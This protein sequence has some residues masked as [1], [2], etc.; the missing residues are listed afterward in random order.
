MIKLSEINIRFGTKTVFDHAEYRAYRGK[1]NII[2]GESGI[3]KTTLLKTILFEHPCMYF[4]DDEELGGLNEKEQAKFLFQHVSAVEQE[5]LFIEDLTLEE[6]RDFLLKVSGKKKK[7]E[8]IAE[9]FGLNDFMD[10][11]PNQLSV[12]ERTRAALWL[13][14]MKHPDILIL[15]EPTASLDEENK[16]KVI[17]LLKEYSRE[18]IVIASSHEKRLIEEADVLYEI[19]DQKLITTI[20]ETEEAEGK[21]QKEIINHAG[22]YRDV[23]EQMDR[24]HKW[25]SLARTIVPALTAA[26][27][28]ISLTFN[29]ITMNR[30]QDALN[31]MSSTEMIVYKQLMDDYPYDYTG[32]TFPVSE[33]EYDSLAK[34][35]GIRKVCPR[36]DFRNDEN[37]FGLCDTD[38][39]NYHHIHTET[40]DPYVLT[41]GEGETQE[42]PSIY[43]E[44]EIV[45]E[46]DGSYSRIDAH[47]FHVYYEG[48][49]YSEDIAKT[50]NDS[51]VYIGSG[52]YQKICGEKEYVQP[53]I[54][55]TVPV[56]AYTCPE[57]LSIG[58]D[59]RPD[60]TVPANTVIYVPVQVKMPVR[61]L[62]KNG[63]MG[64][65]GGGEYE[66]SGIYLELND[67]LKLQSQFQ[68]DDKLTVYWIFAKQL[69]FFNELPD[70]W[71]T[72]DFT[73]E[74][75]KVFHYTKWRPSA[76][77]VFL[78]DIGTIYETAQQIR[79][80]G[81]AVKNDY[82][83]TNA[84]IYVQDSTKKIM[85]LISSVLTA[86]ITAG[87]LIIQYINKESSASLNRYLKETGFNEEERTKF[88]RRKWLRSVIHTSA[89][90]CGLYLVI[91]FV[92]RIA[93]ISAV[94]PM[95][96][97]M[98]GILLFAFVMEYI[99]PYI[100]LKR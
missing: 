1:L 2:A 42:N 93:M 28:F 92:I 19:R 78:E 27:L 38:F 36:I 30:M 22:D 100:L 61:G 81:F 21:K 64:M 97:C 71:K 41:I 9:Y 74:H 56:P 82:V 99:I 32:Q 76:Y 15:D 89:A 43:N 23:Y 48:I 12:G 52:L 69:T 73:G 20:Q 24:H 37:S 3:G 77:S 94:Q 98:A 44:E 67:L 7:Q 91:I 87:Y 85:I 88:F 16:E 25:F 84:I 57:I 68:F 60:V 49:D 11:Y 90:G 54:T 96:I 75:D 13:A 5:P 51:G 53:W 79:D 95:F 6:N 35:S 55:F 34:V 50:I 4:Y 17:A 14:L 47:A 29:N 70:E 86:V 33:E 31:D 83:D 8:R 46:G 10:K 66:H 40:G 80:A 65:S 63:N 72:Y 18:H 39:K 59:S 26:L 62:V 58:M 45:D